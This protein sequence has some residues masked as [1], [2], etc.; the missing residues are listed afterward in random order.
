MPRR[1]AWSPCLNISIVPRC[2]GQSS[3][4]SC[5][6]MTK[7]R[8]SKPASWLHC[9]A[10]T[11]GSKPASRHHCNLKTQSLKPVSGRV[12]NLC[13]VRFKV[14]I[15]NAR[16]KA[17]VLTTEKLC[18]SVITVFITGSIT[19]H[20]RRRVNPYYGRILGDNF[21][22]ET[23]INSSVCYWKGIGIFSWGSLAL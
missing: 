17:R 2:E 3:R 15:Q 5:T 14:G 23:P 7:K 20:I 11:R 22:L 21:T 10:K 12:Q 8:S 6:V 4:P 19:A 9:S 13:L 18:I 16:L 1:R